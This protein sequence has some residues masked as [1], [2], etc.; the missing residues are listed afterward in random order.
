MTAT[1]VPADLVTRYSRTPTGR[2]WLASLP[3]RLERGLRRWDLELDAEAGPWSG[4][5]ALVVAVRRAG[6]PLVLKLPYPHEEAASEAVALRLW[7]GRGAVRLIADDGDG[8]LLLER[9]DAGRRLQEI[10][11]PEAYAVWGAIM[12]RLAVPEDDRPDWAALERLDARAEHWSDELPER[13]ERLGRP[14]PRWLLEEALD[15]CATR[16][17]VGRRGGRDVL[18]H[19]DLHGMN[20]LGDLDGGFRAIDPQAAVGEA[21][22]AVAPMLWNR[23]PELRRTNSA[24][25]LLERCWELADAAGLDGEAARAWAVLREVENALWYAAKPGHRGELERSLWVASA[26][27][28]RLL[29]GLPAANE[30]KRLD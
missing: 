13:W 2:A 7:S 21:E 1:G 26:L 9:L 11:F 23:L 15:V 5:G 20:V 4:F 8:S 19:T 3:E 29:P 24:D 27:C 10:P 30:L 18:V 17:T 14:F 16:G 22:F 12:R 25:A 6:E 28:S